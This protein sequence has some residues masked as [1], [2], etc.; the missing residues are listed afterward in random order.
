ME[1]FA[2]KMVEQFAVAAPPPVKVRTAESDDLS[3]SVAPE[4]SQGESADSVV[5][6]LESYIQHAIQQLRGNAKVNQQFKSGGIPWMGVQSVLMDSIPTVIEARER[7]D[8]AYRMVTRVMNEVFGH[9][10]WT[11]EK[12]DKKSGSGQTTWL[13]PTQ[14]A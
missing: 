14:S 9:G 7:R 10:R 13:V 1:T 2:T 12:R 3:N 11:S 4:M 6:L 8:M 5:D